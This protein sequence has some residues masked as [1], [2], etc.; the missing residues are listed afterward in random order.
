MKLK[1]NTQV[2]KRT[3]VARENEKQRHTQLEDMQN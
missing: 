2:V 1:A 3:V